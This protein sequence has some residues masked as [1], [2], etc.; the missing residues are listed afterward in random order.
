MARRKNSHLAA[1]RENKN[2]SSDSCCLPFCLGIYV[3]PVDLEWF[4]LWRTWGC[5]LMGRGAEME[6]TSEDQRLR[7]CL[8]HGLKGVAGAYEFIS[9]NASNG[10]APLLQKKLDAHTLTVL[11]YGV[12]AMRKLGYV[13]EALG[14][15]GYAERDAS[16]SGPFQFQLEQSN[17]V[18][19]LRELVDSGLS[20]TELKKKG[21]TC[22]HCKKAGY[23]ARQMI[24]IGFSLSEMS[25]V[26]TVYDLKRAGFSISE[27]RNF[28]NG[29]DLRLAGFSSTDM[30]NAGYTIR[31]LKKFGYNDNHIKTAGYSTNDLS[32]EGLAGPTVDK[33]F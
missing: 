21:F 12:A 15:L 14:E 13:E 3:V 22:F 29:N 11:G 17:F 20:A 33:R 18:P 1:L 6:K 7:L 2:T 30:R 4:H 24:D 27:L 16:D 8:A 26:Y 32:R 19:E 5:S 28:F 10:A 9:S 23:D 31:D 25:K